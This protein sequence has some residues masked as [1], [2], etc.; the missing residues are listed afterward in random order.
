V[1]ARAKKILKF[2]EKGSGVHFVRELA[3]WLRDVSGWTRVSVV[4]DGNKTCLHY[5]DRSKRTYTVIMQAL[6][7]V[8]L[9]SIVENGDAA[10]AAPWK[11][12]NAVRNI[13]S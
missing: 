9:F 11:P 10:A 5:G 3:P 6:K 1:N 2:D 13:Q 12:E 7:R 4:A 8:I